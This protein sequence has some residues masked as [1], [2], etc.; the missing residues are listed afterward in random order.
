MGLVV[1]GVL[2]IIIGAAAIEILH[3]KKPELIA[4]LRN[5][6]KRCVDR[7]CPSKSSENKK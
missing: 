7:V 2:G 1:L 4:K 5:S 3:A 6:A